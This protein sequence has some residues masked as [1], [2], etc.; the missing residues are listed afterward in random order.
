MLGINVVPWAI[1]CCTALE[2]M[3]PPLSLQQPYTVVK[4]TLTTHTY[5]DPLADTSYSVEI[6][7]VDLTFPYK[8]YDGTLTVGRGRLYLPNVAE[9]PPEGLPLGISIHYG[10]GPDGAAKFV[11]H[12]WAVL[13]PTHGGKD[14]GGNLVGDGL[15]HTLS[16]VELG[17]RLPWVDTAR[18]AYFGGSAG[19]YQC[20]LAAAMRFGAACAWAEVPISDLYYNI[21]HLVD[22]DRFNE[23]KEH[24]DDWVIP[25][26][27]VVRAVGDLTG[28]ELGADTA[29]WWAYS[30]PP[31]ASLIRQPTAITWSTADILVPI[32]QG[33]DAFVQEPAADAFPD[34][35][36]LD[37][38]ALGNP[39]SNGR[40]LMDFLPAEETETFVLPTA[41]GTLRVPRLPPLK[42]GVESDSTPAPPPAPPVRLTP[43]SRSKRFSIIVYDEGSPDTLCTHR[44][45]R[46]S[47]HN[48]PFFLHH[49]GRGGP[50]ADAMTGDV[51]RYLVARWN[52]EEFVVGLDSVRWYTRADYEPLE[53]WDVLL[54]QETYLRQGPDAVARW[55]SLYRALPPEGRVWD[56][57]ESVEGVSVDAR[58]DE[59]PMAAM[60]YHRWRLARDDRWSAKADE[61]R[62]RLSALYPS[63][64]YTALLRSVGTR[65]VR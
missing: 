3:A 56:V 33:S 40:P 47:Q 31:L 63:S 28:E 55:L 37:Y 41:E 58:A 30:V 34:G 17:R 59:E 62:T 38:R 19:G 48:L 57:S 5:A 7:Q 1:A 14:H 2:P 15:S 18:I 23:G 10:I 45:Y 49:V 51:M 52:G 8:G 21:R 12:G 26:L 29:R 54:A 39:L 25:V 9:P 24:S 64:G 43:W 53:R 22:N 16:M 42:R 27:H 4:D 65:P 60:L 13:T 11:A 20:L 44:K 6:A 46:A 32:N 61:L 50:P 35:F 36:T